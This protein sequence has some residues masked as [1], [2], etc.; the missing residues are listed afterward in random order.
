M[1][2]TQRSPQVQPS[3][4]LNIVSCLEELPVAVVEEEIIKHRPDNQGNG[5]N[6]RRPPGIAEVMTHILLVEGSE[7]A[8]IE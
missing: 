8:V 7:E 1:K 3:L 2:T 6:S 5:V 4:R